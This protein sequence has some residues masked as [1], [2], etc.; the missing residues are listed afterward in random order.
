MTGSE[1]LS[2]RLAG[3]GD[4][5][6]VDRLLSRS[7]PALLRADYPPSVLVT[8]V[9]LIARAQPALLASGSY[10]LAERGGAV[11][12]A[13]GWTKGA[14]GGRPGS[15]GTGHVRHVATDPDH[16]RQGIGRAL[17]ETVMEHARGA[18]MAR[19]EC[20]STRTAVPFYAALGFEARGEVEIALRPG[21]GF[22]A[23]AM[24]AAL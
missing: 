20:L 4:L 24:V 8:A 21:I 17:M 19:L 3:P 13:G 1:A 2:L 22:P 15:R 18:G 5:A 11:L 14:P 10:F 12:A 23:V 7:Y 16:L 9:P 6:A